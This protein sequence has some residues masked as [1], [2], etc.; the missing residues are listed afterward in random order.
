MIEKILQIIVTNILISCAIY[1][2][3]ANILVVI[4]QKSKNKS[5][6]I[7]KLK[8]DE[9]AIDYTSLPALDS[10]ECRDGAA[11]GYR[12]YPSTSR[13]VVVLLHGSGWHST[14]F[15]PLAEYISNENLA[16]VYTPD[17]RGHGSAPA[18]RGDI[19]YIYQLEDDVSDFL[20]TVK[21]AHPDATLIIGGHSSGGG[22]A[23][24]F[25]G[26]RYGHQADAYMLLT[27]FLKYNAPTIRPDSGGWASVHL[28]RIA[29][30]SM[31]NN[32]FI[33]WFNYLPVID[34][35]MP[36]AYRDGTE[37][38]S[39]SYR[40]NTG[41]A[42]RNY[43]KDLKKITQKLFVAAGSSD[44]SFIAEM[45]YPEISKYKDD[46]QVEIIDDVTHMGIVMGEEIRPVLAEWIRGSDPKS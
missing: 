32:I 41:F 25:A 10:F 37:T 7:N 33:K 39:Y 26:S 4:N 3:I 16:H 27:P 36:E 6:S 9:L 20:E 18:R 30:L 15:L 21:K 23:L 1:V 24:R 35:N 45:F 5:S 43:K 22:L 34:F 46:V 19:D 40:L 38:L 28:P 29:G 44:E 11:L 12:Y 8:F 17:L 14:Y 42:P 2:S 13:K 31:L